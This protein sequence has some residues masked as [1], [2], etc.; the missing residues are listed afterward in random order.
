MNSN[1]Q[2]KRGD[3]DSLRKLGFTIPLTESEGDRFEQMAQNKRLAMLASL[4]HEQL[5]KKRAEK[6]PGQST[7]YLKG[8]NR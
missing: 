3:A 1:G 6:Y 7:A 2:I 4:R 8:A 5:A